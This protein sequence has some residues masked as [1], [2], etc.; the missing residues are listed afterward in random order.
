MPQSSGNNHAKPR[1]CSGHCKLIPCAPGSS[2]P[3]RLQPSDVAAARTAPLRRQLVLAAVSPPQRHRPRFP[4]SGKSRVK[5]ET[6]SATATSRSHL[7]GASAARQAI[8]LVEDFVQSA[9]RSPGQGSHA[10]RPGK[11]L[12]SSR[13][14]VAEAP[15]R[16]A[17][18]APARVPRGQIRCSRNGLAGQ[19]TLGL[20]PAKTANRRQR[21]SQATSARVCAR[22]TPRLAGSS[23]LS[24]YADAAASG[25]ATSSRAM[26]KTSLSGS[27]ETRTNRTLVERSQPMQKSLVFC[28]AACDE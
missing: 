14:V 9:G 26:Q 23:R 4:A 11:P 20:S 5:V 18:R 12:V 7:G 17:L 8:D 1:S 6:L 13:N 27:S 3:D 22:D 2:R 16:S 19:P 15:C 25:F 28:I 10:G 21:P 24:G